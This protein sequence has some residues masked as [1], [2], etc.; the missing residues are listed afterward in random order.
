MLTAR[1]PKNLYNDFKSYCNELG[2]SVSE[3]VCLLIKKEVENV[4]EEEN[5]TMNTERI[6]MY[7]DVVGP[8]TSVVK[9]NTNRSSCTRCKSIAFR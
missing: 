7:T 2:I 9:T 6:Q 1:L 4:R 8:T 5:T 3:A